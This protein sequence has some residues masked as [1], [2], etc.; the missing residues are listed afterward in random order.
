M[1]I[2][3]RVVLS[4]YD[5]LI[6]RTIARKILNG[7][8]FL[9]HDLDS[10]EG[11]GSWGRADSAEPIKNAVQRLSP[12]LTRGLNELD[13]P[14]RTKLRFFLDPDSPRPWWLR[15]KGEFIRPSQSTKQV[16]CSG[17]CRDHGHLTHEDYAGQR[18]SDFERNRREDDE[19]GIREKIKKILI[20]KPVLDSGLMADGR[21]R[22]I[23]YTFDPNKRGPGN[24]INNCVGRG[25]KFVRCKIICIW[26]SIGANYSISQIL[27]NNKKYTNK[28]KNQNYS[29]DEGVKHD[30]YRI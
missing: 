13:P 11:Q 12:L 27:Y 6:S 18:F 26:K 7:K 10:I 22:M 15:N 23:H 2:H 20:K 28:F 16:L 1:Q 29:A 14:L 4:F 30:K 9:F 8:Q 21:H 19:V 17:S 5:D 25:L 3:A 24:C